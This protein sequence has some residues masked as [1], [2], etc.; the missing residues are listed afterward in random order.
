MKSYITDQFKQYGD[1]IYHLSYSPLKISG[2]SLRSVSKNTDKDEE[3]KKTDQEQSKILSQKR[4]KATLKALVMCNLPYGNP[5]FL[6]LTYRTPQFNEKQA[7]LDFKNFIKRLKWHTKVQLRYIAVP[8]RHE[9]VFTQNERRYSYHFH[10]IIFDMPYLS[11]KVYADIWKLGFI[12]INRIRGDGL[13]VGL[14]IAK[15]LSKQSS[16]NAHSRRFLASRNVFRPKVLQAIELPLLEYQH[17]RR[18]NRFT[19]GTVRCDIYKKVII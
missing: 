18:Y 13:A 17:A 8:E 4:A 10:I 6:T 11:A 14:Y 9:S 16:H 3:T 2:Q 19:G 7:K 5:K 12:R 15:Y 1:F